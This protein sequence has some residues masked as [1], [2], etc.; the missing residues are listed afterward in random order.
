ML[1]SRIFTSLVLYICLFSTINEILSLFIDDHYLKFPGI[2]YHTIDSKP[3]QNNIVRCRSWELS[4]SVVTFMRLVFFISSSYHRDTNNQCS[5]F[6]EFLKRY[7]FFFLLMNSLWFK[8]ILGC[9]EICFFC[10]AFLLF[11]KL[12]F[13]RFLCICACVICNS[14]YIF[15]LSIGIFICSIFHICSSCVWWNRLAQSLYDFLIFENFG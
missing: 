15:F 3:A 1:I 12:N 6:F 14:F 2:N 4:N 5:V 10:F 8:N 13:F 9:L 7:I 11:L